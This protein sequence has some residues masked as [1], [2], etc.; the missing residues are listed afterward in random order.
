MQSE[1]KLKI[2]L[3]TTSQPT[4]KHNKI[5]SRRSVH[6]L[7][8]SFAAISANGYLFI[9]DSSIRFCWTLLSAG[10]DFTSGGLIAGFI[11]QSGASERDSAYDLH[12]TLWE[13]HLLPKQMIIIKSD[14]QSFLA[15]LQIIISLFAFT[16]QSAVN[17]QILSK[18]ATPPLVTSGNQIL[19]KYLKPVH[20]HCISWSG[21]HMGD[22]VVNGL[23]FSPLGKLVEFIRLARFNCVRLQFSAEMVFKNPIVDKKFLEKYNPELVGLRAIDLY[24]KVVQE[25]TAKKIMVILDLHM[26][27]SGWCCDQNDDNGGKHRSSFVR[28]FKL[29]YYSLMTL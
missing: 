17:A 23:E 11:S 21:F 25:I 8:N 7:I 6:S 1:V 29:M 19:D 22:H 24:H 2:A 4:I 15:A 5:T 27:D 26:L 9:I 14:F 20:L 12:H 10:R 18:L 16:S 28:S 13:S 3:K